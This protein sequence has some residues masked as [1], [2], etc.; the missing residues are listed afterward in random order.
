MTDSKQKLRQRKLKDVREEALERSKGFRGIDKK[1]T[2]MKSAAGETKGGTDALASSPMPPT[3]EQLAKINEFTRSPK[4]A[5]DLVVFDTF[6]CNDLPDRDDDQ[7]TAQTVKDFAKLPAPFGPTG[8]SYMVGHDYNKLPVGR[9]FDTGTQSVDTDS[10]KATF[11]KNS[12]YIPNTAANQSF[13]E[14]QDFGVY[15]AVS[16]GVMLEGVNCNV[17]GERMFQFFGECYNGHFKGAYYDPNSSETDDWGWPIEAK[18]TDKNAIKCLGLMEGAKDFYELSQVFLGAQFYAEL[19]K[20]PQLA[21]VMKAARASHIPVIGLTGKEADALPFAQLPPKARKAVD[22]FGAQYDA[23]G[24]LKWSDDQGL[25]WEFADGEVVCLGK[26][27]ADDEEVEEEHGG[28]DVEPGGSSADDPSPLGDADPEQPDP[29]GGS[30]D[31][32]GDAEP[33][34]GEPGGDGVGAERSLTPAVIAA[35]RARLATV[36][37]AADEGEDDSVK[38]IISTLDDLVDEASTQLDS[39]DTEGAQSTLDQVDSTIDD[40]TTELGIE[41]DDPDDDDKKAVNSPMSK[42]AILA[43]A[44]RAGVPTKVVKEASGAGED[45]ALDVLLSALC[46]TNKE[47]T[48]EVDELKPRAKMGDEYVLDLRVKAIDA[49]VRAHQDGVGGVNTDSFEKLLDSVGDN[50][51]VIRTLIEEQEKTV[52]DKFGVRTLRSSVPTDPHDRGKGDED[53][54]PAQSGR[55]SRLHG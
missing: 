1:F 53:K 40:L 46:T 4:T 43:A 27:G 44:V 34:S 18:A 35:A 37:A 45:K 17:C 15:W 55:V 12:V 38:D 36:R 28:R 48:A 5:D 22:Q 33:G 24:K 11:L 9:I 13:I 8:K 39:G 20:D 14:N 30:G 21:S 49:Y 47:L 6:S 23:E 54:T 7:F 25:A 3:D 2:A 41:L 32:G 31:T 52:R 51:D 42:K 50:V 29:A 16:V 26:Q 10:G 19:E